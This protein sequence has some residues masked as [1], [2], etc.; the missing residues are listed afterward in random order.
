MGLSIPT[1]YAAHGRTRSAPGLPRG[2]ALS[3]RLRRVSSGRRPPGAIP[4]KT[5]GLAR[6]GCRPIAVFFADLR[7]FVPAARQL[8]HAEEVDILVGWNAS[9]PRLV[10]RLRHLRVQR[11]LSWLSLLC[12]LL[13]ACP[14]QPG[15]LPPRT[16]HPPNTAGELA[17]PSSTSVRRL[18]PRGVTHWQAHP[19]RWRPARG[20]E[21]ALSALSERGI[22]RLDL[23]LL[24]HPHLDHLPACGGSPNGSQS[25]CTWTAASRVD[26]P[27]I[28]AC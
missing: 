16:P 13:L 12:W 14:S 5:A 25:R 15:P 21:R 17:S 18:S 11:L 28:S 24:S 19:H 2:R 9:S 23:M 27:P 26:R 6:T 7:N 22:D 20:S 8:P 10:R 4:P 1:A 3:Q